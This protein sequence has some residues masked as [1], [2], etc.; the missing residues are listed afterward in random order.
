MF[1]HKLQI[2]YCRLLEIKQMVERVGWPLRAWYRNI[3]LKIFI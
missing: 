1:N 3:I 2:G